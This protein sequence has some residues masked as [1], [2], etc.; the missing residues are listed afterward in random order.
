MYILTCNN[1]PVY[2]SDTTD[3]LINKMKQLIE[4]IS[5]VESFTI[6]NRTENTIS[7]CDTFHNYVDNIYNI[8]QIELI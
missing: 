2:I 4:Q 3:K 8:R 7:Y 1:Y 5:K 6:L